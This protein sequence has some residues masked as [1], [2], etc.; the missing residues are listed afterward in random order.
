MPLGDIQLKQ[1][2]IMW[3]FII[4]FM[5]GGFVGF[6]ICAIFTS[7]AIQEARSETAIAKDY[8]NLLK[9]QQEQN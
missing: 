5:A 4:G 2:V 9:A 7:N 8:I 3:S 6:L 1:G